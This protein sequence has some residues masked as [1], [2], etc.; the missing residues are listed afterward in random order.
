M[1]DYPQAKP[2]KDLSRFFV[3][4]MEIGGSGT[5]IYNR[6][7]IWNVD[8]YN[9]DLQSQQGML[10]WEK[11]RSSDG[12]VAGALSHVG[13]PFVSAHWRVAPGGEKPKDGKDAT[14]EAIKIADFVSNALFRRPILDGKR[15]GWT[16]FVRHMNLCLPFG[17]ML[18]EKTMEIDLKTGMY[19][20]K[21][22]APRL[23]KSIW[24]YK[25]K[26][27][28]SNDLES[29]CQ[30]AYFANENGGQY[31][32]VHIPAEAVVHFAPFM[33]GDNWF[34]RS[35]LRPAYM[36][37][38]HK[39][40]LLKLDGMRHE[41]H[42]VGIPVMK[43]PDGAGD[44]AHK[45]AEK[46][47]S[48]LRAHERQ[49]V[50]IPFDFEFEIL[51]PTG[52]ASDIMSSC[53]YHDEN[54]GRALLT[55]FV[56]LGA[57][58]SGSRSLGQTKQDFLMLSLQGLGNYYCEV[59]NEYVIKPLV[60]INF[61]EQEEYPCLEIEDLDTMAPLLKAKL[62]QLLVGSKV[63]RTDDPLEDYARKNFYFP[64]RDPESQKRRMT[65]DS[66]A[67]VLG[68]KDPTATRPRTSGNN[69]K[70][71]QGGGNAEDATAERMMYDK[72]IRPIRLSQNERIL[73]EVGKLI[74]T[75][76][77]PAWEI[78]REKIRPLHGRLSSNV[79]KA[80]CERVSEA[81][82]QKDLNPTLRKKIKVLA[83]QFA[84]TATQASVAQGVMAAL[85]GKALGFHAEDIL[86]ITAADLRDTEL[87]RDY[88]LGKYE[89]LTAEVLSGDNLYAGGGA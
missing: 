76:P 3:N 46:I 38:F 86:E 66:P 88:W 74:P 55:E 60:D 15:R 29:V 72:H 53:E 50:K 25:L 10:V 22:I 5:A 89:Y 82:N 71:A 1:A 84:M 79:F 33:E 42:G 61:G 70:P 30:Y 24:Y 37:W 81:T 23:P 77:G 40:E 12:H 57:T 16:S 56:S 14:P 13:T 39:R 63:I 69:D 68:P 44:E 43:L 58:A 73:E 9:P 54:I 45:L 52:T 32:Q 47:L 83:D 75:D 41:R 8:D 85:S 2:P 34:G 36:H 7:E 17:H 59:M 65:E 4:N 27:D 28:G 20:Y 18:F 62:L 6:G 51:Y 31:R 21:K 11:M 26:T 48:E 87:E 78:A 49:F 80:V 35:I 67:P 19:V 64:K